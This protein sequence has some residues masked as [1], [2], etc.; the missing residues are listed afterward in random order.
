MADV[1]RPTEKTPEI[2][3]KIEEAA[4]MDCSIEEMALLANIH[5][6]TL[7]RWLKEDDE[8][9]DRIAELRQTPFLLARRTVIKGIG[10]KYDNAM[11]YLKRKKKKEFGDNVDITSGNKPLPILTLSNEIRTDDSD[12]QNNSVEKEN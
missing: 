4:A 5:R 6:A 9:S 12:K 7:Y 1:G 10:E 8:F 11:D 2:I 3:R